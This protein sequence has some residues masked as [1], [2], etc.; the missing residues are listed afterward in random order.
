MLAKIYLDARR[1]VSDQ[2]LRDPHAKHRMQAAQL[3]ADAAR[4][5]LLLA[6]ARGMGL[7]TI[8]TGFYANGK[9]IPQDGTISG[10]VIAGQHREL[11]RLVFDA[12]NGG[13]GLSTYNV[14]VPPDADPEETW[15]SFWEEQC[16]VDYG[17][18]FSVTQADQAAWDYDLPAMAS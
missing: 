2:E 3:H 16:G 1:H 6:L 14:Q 4:V 12:D 10:W 7:A 11:A 15:E 9:L 17:V 13:Y 5:E 18:S 8:E